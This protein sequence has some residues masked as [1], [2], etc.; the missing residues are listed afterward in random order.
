MMKRWTHPAQAPNERYL[1]AK[2][3]Q[4]DNDIREYERMF[5]DTVIDDAMRHSTLGEIIP[6]ELFKV[7]FAGSHLD[8]HD[9]LRAELEAYLQEM[10]SRQQ[11]AQQDKTVSSFEVDEGS[12]TSSSKGL[13]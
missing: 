4:W 7:R 10:R 2:V 6:A 8:D 3:E 11:T 5:P 1:L 13:Q 12:D 9:S